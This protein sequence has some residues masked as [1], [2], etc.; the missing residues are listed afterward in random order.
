MFTGE[1]RKN[2]RL[3]YFLGGALA[4]FRLPPWKT[5]TGFTHLIIR[6]YFNRLRHNYRCYVRYIFD[7][8]ILHEAHGDC[9]LPPHSPDE[10]LGK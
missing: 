7:S 5:A 2:Y 3:G 4:P 8:E 9:V 10:S 1:A 6:R